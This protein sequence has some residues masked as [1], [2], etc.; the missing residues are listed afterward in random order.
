MDLFLMFIKSICFM[1]LSIAPATNPCHRNRPIP[2]LIATTWE[3][4]R[5]LT[6]DIEGLVH[7]A[8]A[9][10]PPAIQS[11]LAQDHFLQVLIPANLY[12]QML[13]AHPRSL[14]EA[15]ELDL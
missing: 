11:E 6:N 7:R 15:L 3:S 4:L 2:Q 14:L 1:F 8:Y 12:I 10:M 9:H 5:D 13:L